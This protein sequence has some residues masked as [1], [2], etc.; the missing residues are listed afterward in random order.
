MPRLEAR[1]EA[2]RVM[3]YLSP[4]VAV[5]LMLAGGA[6][7]F[8]AL[9]K[10]PLE[11]FRVFFFNPVKDTYGLT[12][13]LL[14][15]TPLMLIAVGLAAGFRANVWNIGAEGQFIAGAAAASGVA[16]HFDSSGA[17]TL[18]PLMLLAG[19]AGG[20]AWAAIPA[21][22]R[23][24]FN[25]NEILVSLMLVYIAQLGVSWLVHGPWKDPEGYNFPQTKM[26]A[27]AALLP[28]LVEGTR[29]NAAFLFALG[30]LAAGY[31]FMQKSFMGFQM[32]V[33]GQA[34]AAARY[35]GFSAQR[36]IW[37][38]LLAGGAMA[39]I[40][41]MAEVAGPMGQLTEHV[42]NNY[43]FAA[44]IVAFVGRLN[45]L[46]IA[47]ASLLMALL[48]LGGEQA[49]QYLNLPSSISLVFQG[50]LLFFLLGADIF[51]NYRLRFAAA[52]S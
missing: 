16:L 19:A 48:Y 46:G 50:M 35:A 29:L 31:V 13:L 38:G 47:C 4:L 41:G 18:L 52:A 39:G 21:W 22:L 9:G 32:Q 26:F 40:A 11:G 45:P 24:R 2:S 43:G 14:K 7:V 12:E 6:L 3:P 36:T 37:T 23:T 51:I 25:A 33:A 42:S 30:A 17:A 27:D 44:I 15:A 34:E 10:S 49:Q 1:P 28:L 20:A 8:A 5:L